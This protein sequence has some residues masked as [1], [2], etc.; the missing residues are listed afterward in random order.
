[1]PVSGGICVCLCCVCVLNATKHRGN[2]RKN[3]G[4]TQFSLLENVPSKCT[5]LCAARLPTM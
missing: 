2:K 4:Q 3:V 1:M 5:Q